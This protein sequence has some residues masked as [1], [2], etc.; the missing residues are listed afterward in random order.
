MTDYVLLGLPGLYQNWL[1]SALDTHSKFELDFENNFCCN[2]SRIHWIAK[3]D[4]LLDPTLS[5]CTVINTYVSN[6]NFV[7]FLYNFLEKTDGVGLQVDHLVEDL[8]N[9][10]HGARAFDS[11][12]KHW[13]DSYNIDNHPDPEYRTNSIIEYFYFLLLDTQN[14]FKHQVGFTDPRFVNIEYCDFEDKNL[15]ENKLSHLEIF[16]QDHFNHMYDLLYHRNS[17]YLTRRQNFVNKIR[18]NN[19]QFDILEVA[20]IGML[21]TDQDPIDWFNSQLRE[22]TINNRW[23]DICNH[24]DNLL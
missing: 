11:M 1:L 22:N 13:V 23:L 7:W 9:K 21:I 15:L 18:S 14:A 19:K 8:K 3:I 2:Q 10:A 5:D 12:R 24:A 17:Q 4:E 16:D 20:Y 6:E